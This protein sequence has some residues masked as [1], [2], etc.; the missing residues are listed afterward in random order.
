MTDQGDT[1]QLQDHDKPSAN[2]LWGLQPG[3]E[4]ASTRSLPLAGADSLDPTPAWHTW[5]SDPSGLQPRAH[6]VQQ[7]QLD[8]LQP[9]RVGVWMGWGSYSPEHL[10]SK[11]AQT[12]PGAN[13]GSILPQP[14]QGLGIRAALINHPMPEGDSPPPQQA[15]P[16]KQ[17]F[18]RAKS[19]NW[20]QEKPAPG[21][22]TPKKV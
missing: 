21:R 14:V 22:S 11:W 19:M 3:A 7:T 5:E 15:P 10:T 1:S 20:V 18:L 8:V 12:A 13:M 2:R 4:R 6:P 16:Q 17:G 9:R